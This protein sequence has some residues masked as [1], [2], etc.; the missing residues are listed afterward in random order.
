MSE[1][2][3]TKYGLR[4]V[5]HDPPTLKEAISAAEGLTS[6][7]HQQAEIAAALMDLDV[8]EARAEL[9]RTAPAR[10][11]GHIV[12]SSSREGAART[13]IVERKPR[14]R[15]AAPAAPAAACDTG[16]AT[17]EDRPERISLRGGLQ[18]T[19]TC[20]PRQAAPKDRR[21]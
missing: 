13:V 8:D 5:R 15:I 12:T 17:Q 4:R 18:R 21:S 14:R 16:E 2:W 20:S 10:R 3:K 6:D 9:L 19:G 11:S 1:V 7:I